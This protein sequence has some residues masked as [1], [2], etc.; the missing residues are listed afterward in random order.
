M[1]LFISGLTEGFS[2]NQSERESQITP[3]IFSKSLA[4]KFSKTRVLN[5][6]YNHGGSYKFDTDFENKKFDRTYVDQTQELDVN[7]NLP[8]LQGE[9]WKFTYSGSYHLQSYTFDDQEK[10]LDNEKL[11]YMSSSASFTYFSSLF[12][13]PMIYSGSLILDAS[14]EMFG[15]IKGMASA[16]M[17]LK[18]ERESSWSVGV[19]G[20]SNPTI[21]TP[22]VPIISHSR[23][24]FDERW[25]LDVVL[26]I[27]AMMQTQLGKTVRLSMGTEL[28]TFSYYIKSDN[29]SETTSRYE[30]GE[31]Q[32]KTGLTY[33]YIISNSFV[34][35]AKA[36]LMSIVQSRII[37]KGEKFTKNNYLV[38][39][40][41]GAFGYF[42]LGVSFNPF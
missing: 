7:V 30:Y 5:I 19:I 8:I 28:D 40:D 2:Q 24:M 18:S 37:K 21:A 39:F 17:V 29:I 36:G 15:R 26:P 34:L 27:K 22:I 38:D 11:H 10:N 13:K 16:T 3:D 9:N 12:K 14:G 25:R 32:L 1:I 35:T 6:E 33:E 42:N 31:L 41:S 23:L 20:L 4:E